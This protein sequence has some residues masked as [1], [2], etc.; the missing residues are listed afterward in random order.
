MA[1]LTDNT[2]ET[3][4]TAAVEMDPDTSSA[5]TLCEWFEEYVDEGQVCEEDIA[6]FKKNTDIEFLKEFFKAGNVYYSLNY[7]RNCNG[8]V[9][10]A[11]KH[12]IPSKEYTADKQMLFVY[13][14]IDGK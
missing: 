10:D 2:Y 4:K 9:N 14:N 5:K 6:Y 1:N 12:M 13:V 3:I 11:I 7:R 8:V